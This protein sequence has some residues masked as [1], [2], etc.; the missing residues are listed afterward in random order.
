VWAGLSGFESL[1]VFRGPAHGTDALVL[2]LTACA[3]HAQPLFALPNRTGEQQ[4]R[5]LRMPMRC[6]RWQTDGVGVSQQPERACQG[7]R[8]CPPC[9]SPLMYPAAPGTRCFP[10]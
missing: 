1:A 5:S 6:V 4:G 2:W 9:N 3:A 8:S 10:S 7:E